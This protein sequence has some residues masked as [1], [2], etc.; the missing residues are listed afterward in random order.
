MSTAA[1]VSSL[2]Y[3]LG[4]ILRKFD[5]GVVAVNKHSFEF[6]NFKAE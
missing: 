1:R 4:A 5:T 6:M 2:G 3:Y